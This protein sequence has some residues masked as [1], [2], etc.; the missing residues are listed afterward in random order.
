MNVHCGERYQGLS[1]AT[2]CNHSGTP[3]RLPFLRDP[4]RSHRLRGERHPK[5]RAKPG[6]CRIWQIVQCR[7]T[8]EDAV[9]KFGAEYAQVI[10]N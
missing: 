10:G 3:I 9:A 8:L 6:R 5:E 2:F 4:H 7:K 1:R